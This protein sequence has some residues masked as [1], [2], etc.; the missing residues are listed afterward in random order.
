MVTHNFISQS[1]SKGTEELPVTGSGVP[2]H[3][4]DLKSRSQ[5][6]SF[7]NLLLL[8]R[9]AEKSGNGSWLLCLPEALHE[10]HCLPVEVVLTLH[11]KQRVDP[12]RSLLTTRF[13]APTSIA[14]Q[15]NQPHHHHPNQQYRHYLAQ[16]KPRTQMGYRLRDLNF[17]AFD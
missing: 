14:A 3:G 17:V 5:I 13:H 2:A 8:V 9:T 12:P 7:V 11:R 4:R 10:P 6:H 16:I 15:T 1:N